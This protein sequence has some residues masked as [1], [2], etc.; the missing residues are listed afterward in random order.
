MAFSLFV[1][2]SSACIWYFSQNDCHLPVTKSFYR[3]IRYHLGS[4][5]FGALL[6]TIVQ[7]IRIVLNYLKAKADASGATK[8]FMVKALFIYLNY[9]L[10]YVERVIQFINRNAYI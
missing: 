4:L 8:N 6:V 7:M 10:W 3:G 1:I 2:A 9:Y 5:A